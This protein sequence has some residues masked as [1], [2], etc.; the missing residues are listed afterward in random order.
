LLAAAA[1]CFAIA[2]TRAVIETTSVG[3]P[4]SYRDLCPSAFPDGQ[5]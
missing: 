1:D 3:G 2:C 4:P 5:G